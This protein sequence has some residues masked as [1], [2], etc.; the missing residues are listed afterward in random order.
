MGKQMKEKKSNE[1][2]N[3]RGREWNKQTWL[4]F[5]INLHAPRDNTA[6]LSVGK[7]VGP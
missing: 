2:F 4:Y 1:L 6:L 3:G 5:G 7:H